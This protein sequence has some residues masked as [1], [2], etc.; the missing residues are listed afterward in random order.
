M[1]LI[2]TLVISLVLWIVLWGVGA[3]AIDAFMLS[4]VLMLGAAIVHI[5]LPM[6]P[7]NRRRSDD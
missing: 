6:L 3:K 1:I 2:V 4:I 7:G 5:V